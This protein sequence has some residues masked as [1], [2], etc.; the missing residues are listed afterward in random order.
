[1][2]S[3]I[4]KVHTPKVNK[5]GNTYIKVDMI[6]HPD[7]KYSYTYLNPSNYNYSKLQNLIETSDM[8]WVSNLRWKDECRGIIDADSPVEYD[9]NYEDNQ[10]D[11]FCE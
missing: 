4:T 3:K 8:I 6:T 7:S 11:L 9:S 2:V 1:M 10:L 5:F